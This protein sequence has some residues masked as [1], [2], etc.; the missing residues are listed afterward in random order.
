MINRIFVIFTEK[1]VKM[2]RLIRVE[3]IDRYSVVTSM[4]LSKRYKR[5]IYILSYRFYEKYVAFNIRLRYNFNN[6]P[7]LLFKYFRIY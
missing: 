5:C 7:N 6:T 3:V 2:L 4:I 1:E